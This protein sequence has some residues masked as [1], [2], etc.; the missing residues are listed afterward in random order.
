MFPNKSFHKTVL[1]NFFFFN[2][3]AAEFIP[4][5]VV[6]FLTLHLW[7]SLQDFMREREGKA[8]KDEEQNFHEGTLIDCRNRLFKILL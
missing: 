6:V 4:S 3:W 2:P 1:S 7:T 8:G 5:L